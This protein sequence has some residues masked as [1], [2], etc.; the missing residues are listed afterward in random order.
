M[1][2]ASIVMAVV[3][4]VAGI[5]AFDAAASEGPD[6]AT[7]QAITYGLDM[8]SMDNELCAGGE[9]AFPLARVMAV[10]VRP[11]LLGGGSASNL[12]VGGRVEVQFRTAVYDHLR[13][14]FGAGPQGFYELRG[15]EAHQKDFSGGWDVGLE[16]L[17]SDRLA[18]HWEIGTSGGGVFG[19]AG[20]VF[21]VGARAS[22]GGSPR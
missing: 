16:F 8:Q 17:L 20:P 9:I 11:M 21:A 18:L 3:V 2:R 1:S 6:A 19:G 10:V 7:S 14:Y 5:G 12:D 4:F 15:S 13:A 22:L